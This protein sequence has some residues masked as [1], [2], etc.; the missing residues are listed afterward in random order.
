MRHLARLLLAVI[1][2]SLFHLHSAQA[3]DQPTSR[4]VAAAGEQ[5]QLLAEG[6]AF[7]E[8]PA[9]DAAGN[10]YFTDQ[11][12]D[13]IVKWDAT[14]GK[15]STFLEPAGRSNGL[16][17]D[18][19]GNLIACADEKNEL[20]SIAPD[21][22]VTVLFK[23]YE[24]KMMNGPNDLWIRPDGAIYFTDPLYKRKYW[25]RN[26]AAEQPM[27]AVYLVSPD[28]KTVKR[29][30]D[31]LRQPNGIIGTPDGKRLYI[32]DIGAKQTFA[33]DIGADGQLSNKT[34]FC[35]MGSDGM[36]IDDEGNIYLTNRGVT[37]FDK[38][39]AKIDHI[40]I[41]QSW[42][43]NICFGGADRRMLFI[44]A[45]KAVY[46]LKTRVKGVGSP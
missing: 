2:I 42:T 12:N 46:G 11:P 23:D 33:Y 4:P 32:S 8:G 40:A 16:S 17:F 35:A 38:T 25:T 13:R 15:T 29:V 18:A 26:P 44:T 19:A 36:T 22:K 30:V 24:G 20:W 1:L 41:N 14:S 6:F 37:V 7:T 43:A 9:A 28:R 45:S 39:G 31:D 27:Q 34:P 10:V 3:A 5:V 21:K